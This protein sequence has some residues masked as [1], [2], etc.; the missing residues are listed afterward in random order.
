MLEIPG[1]RNTSRK[2]F[3]ILPGLRQGKRGS[4]C[5][6]GKRSTS[7]TLG[8][9]QDPQRDSGCNPRWKM[10]HGTLGKAVRYHMDTLDAPGILFWTEG[11]G[12]KG[13]SRRLSQAQDREHKGSGYEMH[14]LLYPVVKSC[15]IPA[16]SLIIMKGIINKSSQLLSYVS[17]Y[18]NSFIH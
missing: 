15:E 9:P 1:G 6:L 17:S 16:F 8:E 12:D 18:K 13:L 7:N 14:I 11:C 10:F 3:P 2:F 4:Y 5:S